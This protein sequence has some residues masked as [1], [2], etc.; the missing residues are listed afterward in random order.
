MSAALEASETNGAGH[1]L[2]D[3]VTNV[4]HGSVDAFQL[5][6]TAHKITAGQNSY[7]KQIQWHL[8]SLGGSTSIGGLRLWSPTTRPAFS[9]IYFNG[10]TDQTAYN[11]TKITSPIT[12]AT[13]ATRT[14]NALPS[15]D[16]G[17]P[18]IGIGGT[19]VSTLTTPG[20]SDY[21]LTQ[22][23]L[24]VACVTSADPDMVYQYDETL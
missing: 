16:P 6:P 18:N 15:T 9:E 23:R 13:T 2:T 21:V 17:L 4:H 14:P 20:Y 5:D 3:G 24:N 22:V 1:V 11:S 10:N 8:T 12:P 19:L 7:E